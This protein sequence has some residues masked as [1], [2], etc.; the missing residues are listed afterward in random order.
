VAEFLGT[1]RTADGGA[2]LIVRANA[3]DR[4]RVRREAS[5]GVLFTEA[6]D[7]PS[8][9]RLLQDHGVLYA[10]LEAAG[11]AVEEPVVPTENFTGWRDEANERIAFNVGISQSDE[12]MDEDYVFLAALGSDALDRF[13]AQAHALL[14]D[15][16]T[17]EDAWMGFL[18]ATASST[19]EAMDH[20]PLENTAPAEDLA[21]TLAPP[22]LSIADLEI[23]F[24]RGA[25]G[26]PR[27][28]VDAVE[29]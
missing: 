1:A 13:L 24:T 17:T 25:L 29:P 16:G 15:Q 10:V 4:E 18:D 7:M 26:G 2:P 8:L 11:P 20:T 6:A 21:E 14:A 5:G 19:D 22:M 9:E 3:D 12:V 28:L 23:E 27:P